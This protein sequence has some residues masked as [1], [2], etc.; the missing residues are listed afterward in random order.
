MAADEPNFES[1]E[2]VWVRNFRGE[3]AA[4]EKLKPLPAQLPHAKFSDPEP[5]P[6]LR[7]RVGDLVQLTFVN[8][9]NP[10]NFD[11]NIDFQCTKVGTGGH[12]T[13][14]LSATL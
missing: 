5:G 9:V 2:G 6:T 4:G 8:E 7:A 10:N 1:D 13:L 3:T 12:N 14:K 11:P